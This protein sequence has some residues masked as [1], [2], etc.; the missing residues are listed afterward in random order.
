MESRVK[1]IRTARADGF[2]LVY[3][4]KQLS[5]H[6]SEVHYGILNVIQSDERRR[7]IPQL[8]LITIMKART[9]EEAIVPSAANG[10]YVSFMRKSDST[11]RIGALSHNS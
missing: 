3:Q 1:I 2:L 7:W 8:M 9:G 6:R 4:S 11:R 5:S 10:I